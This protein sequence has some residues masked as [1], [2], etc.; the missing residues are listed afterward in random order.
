MLFVHRMTECTCYFKTFNKWILVSRTRMWNICVNERRS[1]WKNQQLY[2]LLQSL[3]QTRT[4]LGRVQAS[5]RANSLR[6][7]SH[8]YTRSGIN[9]IGLFLSPNQLMN[10]VLSQ[11]VHNSK[12]NYHALSQ[13]QAFTR[14]CASKCKPMICVCVCIYVWFTSFHMQHTATGLHYCWGCKSVADAVPPSG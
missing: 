9:R 10:L 3:N 8:W 1:G 11:L 2:R 7:V 4:A 12:I 5:T 14:L 6:F 13:Q